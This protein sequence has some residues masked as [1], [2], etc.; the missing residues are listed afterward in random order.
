[1]VLTVWTAASAASA[2]GTAELEQKTWA[3][4]APDD[5]RV[6][7]NAVAEHGRRGHFERIFPP[8]HDAAQHEAWSKLFSTQRY[9]NALLKKF[10]TDAEREL[11]RA[12]KSQPL[13]ESTL[14]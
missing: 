1:M 6:V 7:Y 9:A 3:Q 2:R 5:K 10:E 8:A 12:H 14:V 13:A 11:A 4:L